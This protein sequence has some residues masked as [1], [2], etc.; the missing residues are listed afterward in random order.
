M[1]THFVAAPFSKLA[2]VWPNVNW[3]NRHVGF[4]PS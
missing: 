4:A 3:L 1:I 2:S